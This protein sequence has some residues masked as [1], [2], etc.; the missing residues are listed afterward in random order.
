MVYRT[1]LIDKPPKLD[2]GVRFE[3]HKTREIDE[4]LKCLKP[5]CNGCPKG[6]RMTIKGTLEYL[7]RIKSIDAKIKSK[8]IEYDAVMGCL[9]PSGIRYDLDK[10]QTSQGDPMGAMVAKAVDL[11]KEVQ[12][13]NELRFKT[14]IALTM[15]IHMLEDETE[16]VVLMSY[17]IARQPMDEL[18]EELHYSISGIYNKKDMSVRHLAKLLSA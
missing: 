7:T 2:I 9:L 17:F 13:L 10:I 6:E 4:C 15:D 8:R 18:A 12:A 14:L 11:D 3:H 1:E 16:I 5:E